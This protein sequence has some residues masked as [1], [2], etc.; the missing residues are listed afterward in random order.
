MDNSTF[1]TLGI[2]NEEKWSEVLEEYRFVFLR[3]LKIA[4]GLLSFE[5]DLGYIALLKQFL[6]NG[7]V[8]DDPTKET[9]IKDAIKVLYY[10]YNANHSVSGLELAIKQ[11]EADLSVTRAQEK[12]LWQNLLQV[13]DKIDPRG[14]Y[15]GYD[16][17][18]QIWYRDCAEKQHSLFVDDALSFDR[19]RHYEK[20]L[21]KFHQK[22]ALP[23]AQEVVF[24][25]YYSDNPILI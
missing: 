14:D 4:K 22:P 13:I 3:Y 10:R 1:K 21:E 7:C 24:E 15:I 18:G 19:V 25:F 11:F 6:A 8:L 23:Y 12:L 20:V 17:Y 9:S 5:K 2:E 16:N